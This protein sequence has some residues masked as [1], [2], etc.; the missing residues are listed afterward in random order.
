M[1]PTALYHEPSVQSSH[2][3]PHTC[4]GSDLLWRCFTQIESYRFPLSG[5]LHNKTP[6]FRPAS[7]FFFHTP[8]RIL[9]HE[10]FLPISALH[11]PSGFLD[12]SFFPLYLL[13]ESFAFQEAPPPPPSSWELTILTLLILVRL[14]TLP[15]DKSR[16]I[17]CV[18]ASSPSIPSLKEACRV[19]CSLRPPPP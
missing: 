4:H 19:A 3:L 17:R 2:D 6:F 1:K 11:S 8:R 18:P 10:L 12:S 5:G 7:T 15:S 13:L 9:F 14:S 16:E